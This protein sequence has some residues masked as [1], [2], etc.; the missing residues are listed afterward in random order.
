MKGDFHKRIVTT[1]KKQKIIDETQKEIHIIQ[2]KQNSSETIK[3][4]IY[5]A[6]K[7]LYAI[8]RKKLDLDKEI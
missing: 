6:G 5:K 3:T 4:T 7:E 2:N 1:L 8:F